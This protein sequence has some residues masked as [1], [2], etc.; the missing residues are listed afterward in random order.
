MTMKLNHNG[1]N[2]PPL[3]LT[4]EETLTQLLNQ[5]VLK[6]KEDVETQAAE[7]AIKELK[8]AKLTITLSGAENAQLTRMAEI[9][10]CS[11]KEF[12]LTTIH[13]QLLDSNVA[14]PLIS[15]PSSLSGVAT[16]GRKIT[17]P[18]GLARRSS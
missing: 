13:E 1:E 2:V 8:P 12:I 16:R 6:P 4:D 15:A 10:G 18:T 5:D 11:V 9:K 3:D 14:K 7:A 17:A